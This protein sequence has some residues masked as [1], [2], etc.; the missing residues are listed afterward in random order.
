MSKS[1]PKIVLYHEYLSGWLWR[2]DSGR[3]HVRSHRGFMSKG[4]AR[5]DAERTRGKMARAVV[6]EE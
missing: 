4:A 5:L 6:V 1:R 2:M 3:V